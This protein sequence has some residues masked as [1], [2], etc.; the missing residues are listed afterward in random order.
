MHCCLSCW[1]CTC[2]DDEKQQSRL[3]TFTWYVPHL[4]V[5]GQKLNNRQ[6][7]DTG[8]YS[9]R[10]PSWVLQAVREMPSGQASPMITFVAQHLPSMVTIPASAPTQAAFAEILT[11]CLTN[12][13]VEVVSAPSLADAVAELLQNSLALA[14]APALGGLS[15][16]ASG[17]LVSM[18]Q[19]VKPVLVKGP[20]EPDSA[21]QHAQQ[22]SPADL[23]GVPQHAGSAANLGPQHA[24]H[25]TEAVGNQRGS[26]QRVS[27]QLLGCLLKLYSNAV[28]LHGQCAATQMQIMPLPG[29][30][31]GLTTQQIPAAE[32]TGK[33]NAATDMSARL[34]CYGT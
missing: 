29:Q 15:H 23:N 12:I 31:T 22:E 28:N 4:L 20:A 10:R 1:S 9:R 18:Q 30:G 19:P 5:K 3:F 16:K 11:T 7:F 8:L 27:E 13:R 17:T 25:D 6:A 33:L 21:P 34:I 32:Q 2:S 14:L 26:H 24:Q